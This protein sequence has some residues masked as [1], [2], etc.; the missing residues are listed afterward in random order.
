MNTCTVFPVF[1][2][3]FIL[4]GYLLLM[5]YQTIIAAAALT[6]SY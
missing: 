6:D 3:I 1:V 2:F 5:F 4:L